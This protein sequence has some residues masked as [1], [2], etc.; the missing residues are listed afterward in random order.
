MQG[1]TVTTGSKL[2]IHWQKAFKPG[3]AYVMLGRCESIKDIY[4]SGEFDPANIK[5]DKAAL[6]EAQRI[7]EVVRARDEIEQLLQDKMWTVS[8]IN[9]RSLPAHFE[10]VKS[11]PILKQSHV[12]A[13]GETWMHPGQAFEL[14]GYKSAFEN[15]GDGK[16]LATYSRLQDSTIQTYSSES[17]KFSAA[18]VI[19]QEFNVVFAYLSKGFDRSAF[20]ELLD[21]WIQDSIPTVL[22]GDVNWHWNSNHSMK[23]YM[24][25][26]GFTQLIQKATHLEGHI[27]DHVYVSHHFP[28]EVIRV[29]QQ[30]VTFSDH[31]VITLSFPK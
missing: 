10:D 5:C 19:T 31:D 28:G 21:H 24:N 30:S 3:M 14:D 8:F 4:I 29:A 6:A 9:V 16:G 27:L 18:L 26:R 15:C 2:V 11:V 22:L 20:E 13:C 17:E 1:V 7:D 25:R 12:F 23:R